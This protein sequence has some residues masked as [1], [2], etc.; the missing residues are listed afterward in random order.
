MPDD[1]TVRDALCSDVDAICGFGAA[2]IP[3][4]Y[5]PLIGYDAARAQVSRWWSGERIS[6]AV[7]AGQVVVAEA[8]STLIGVAERGEWDGVPVIWKLYVHP[9]HRGQGIGPKLL[10]ALIARLPAQADRL[11]VEVFAANLRA[12][13]FYAREGFA[14]LSTDPDPHQ[15]ALAVVWRELDLTGR[16]RAG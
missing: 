9:D 16:T 14:Y 7:E 1:L 13:E 6:T 10:R 15:P 5:A 11:Q 3:S 12:Q 8:E 2:H 4:H